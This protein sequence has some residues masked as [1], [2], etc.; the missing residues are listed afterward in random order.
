MTGNSFVIL[1]PRDRNENEWAA[2][3]NISETG[4]VFVS[5]ATRTKQFK[6]YYVTQIIFIYNIAD[7]NGTS[8]K[9]K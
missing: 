8:Y 9:K 6:A 3:L 1:A 5:Y 2:V 7:K 4:R